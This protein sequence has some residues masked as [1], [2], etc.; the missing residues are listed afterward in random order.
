MEYEVEVVLPNVC[1]AFYKASIRG[2]DLANSTAVVSFE[3]NWQPTTTVQLSCVR[4]PPTDSTVVQSLECG[5][6]VEAYLP[7]KEG[8]EPGWWIGKIAKVKGDL[9]VV[10]FNDGQ[11]TYT[12]ILEKEKLRL[13]NKNPPLTDLEFVTKS[14]TVPVEIQDY[15]TTPGVHQNFRDKINALFVTYNSTE[16]CLIVVASN[17][18]GIEKSTLLIDLH[19]KNLRTMHMLQ[20]HN[21]EAQQKIQESQ[22][23]KQSVTGNFVE[24][25]YVPQSL[26]GIAI[27]SGGSNVGAARSITGVI[28]IDLDDSTSTFTIVG[29]SKEAVR[30]ARGLLEYTVETISIPR[31]Y[32]GKV[33]GK[34]GNTIQGIMEKSR[35]LN[36]KIM[37]DDEARKKNIDTKDKVPFVFTGLKNAV[38]NAKLMLEYHME[39]LKTIE[40]LVEDREQ[41]DQQLRQLQIGGRSNYFPAPGRGGM[42][43]PQASNRP[44]RGRGS[45]AANGPSQKSNDDNF[46][47]DDDSSSQEEESAFSRGEDEEDEEEEEEEEEK[48]PEPSSTFSTQQ[49]S[50]LRG[51]RSNFRGRSRGR[52]Y[53]ST[54]DSNSRFSGGN[55]RGGR[56]NYR[57]YQRGNR[58][59]SN[60]RQSYGSSN[61]RKS[62]QD[63]T[64]KDAAEDTTH[65]TPQVDN[66]EES[67]QQQQQQEQ[68]QEAPQSDTTPKDQRPPREKRATASKD[69]TSDSTKVEEPST[70]ESQPASNGTN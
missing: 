27:G 17:Q 53:R 18:R 14:Y 39:H 40:Q 8:E 37:G 68:Q 1:G 60:A 41:L 54:S 58:F 45:M 12:D 10:E 2:L 65:E 4:Y 63:G 69:A 33:I 16:Q 25:V 29:D 31:E 23:Q 30:E 47:S 46:Q 48:A 35:V 22:K 9:Y 67:Q 50:D 44:G 24:E 66:H 38:E 19:F 61:T 70:T 59:R 52:G 21:Q 56:G 64:K 57:G 32:A 36:V 55:F 62:N 42:R 3:N 11:S 7:H 6:Q 20:S 49:G 15:C 13:P 26:L 43:P 5:S 34:K 51:G 28:S